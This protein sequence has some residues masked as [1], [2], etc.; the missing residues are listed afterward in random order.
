MDL[1]FMGSFGPFEILVQEEEDLGDTIYSL[2]VLL[3]GKKVW[4]VER[5][6][7]ASYDLQY[8]LRRAASLAYCSLDAWR[9]QVL[10]AEA[11][12]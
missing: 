4:P 6:N 11:R 2:E 9:Q 3:E 8:V 1:A 12:L 10:R 5:F 7:K